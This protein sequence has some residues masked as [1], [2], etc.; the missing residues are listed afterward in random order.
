M[1][2]IVKRGS[3][4]SLVYMMTVHGRRKQKWETYRSLDE[5]EKEREP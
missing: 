2:S 5:A 3:S 4:Y 1:A